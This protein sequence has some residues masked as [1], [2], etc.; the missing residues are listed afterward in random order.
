[1]NKRYKRVC[2]GIR[3]DVISGHYQAIKVLNGK[4]AVETF[5]SLRE[6]K[7]WFKSYTPKIKT[8]TITKTLGSTLGEALAL[9]LENHVAHLA[10]NT[11]Q[12]VNRR[13][14]AFYNKEIKQIEITAINSQMIDDYLKRCIVHSSSKG[15]SDC[16][17]SSYTSELKLSR[18]FFNWYSANYNET[19]VNPIKRRHFAMGNVRAN[20]PKRRKLTKVEIQLFFK[21]LHGMFLGLAKIQFFT[22]SRI[23]EVAGLH[24]TSVNE[25]NSTLTIKHCLVWSHSTKKFLEIKETPK[26]ETERVCYINPAIAM[27]LDNRKKAMNGPLVFH[28]NGMPLS[29]RQIQY[30]YRKALI[31]SGLNDVTSSHFLRHS[32][33]NLVRSLGG[34]DLAQSITG[35]KHRLIVEKTYT[36]MPNNLQREASDLL[37]NI[38][39][40]NNLT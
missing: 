32:A 3:Q 2:T 1:M 30:Q 31:K 24:W 22:A 36:E 21:N 7:N 16:K 15:L 10:S 5:K 23:S 13:L 12:T 33:A 29:Y 17:R 26:N 40:N 37:C 34:L 28:E 20:N 35:H 6:A 8:C 18:T 27:A 9:Y 4:Q 25:A 11:R 19:L 14:T 39:N 38:F